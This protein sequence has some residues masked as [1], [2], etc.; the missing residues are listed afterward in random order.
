MPSFD[1]VSEVDKHEAQNAVDQA[2]REL[3][4]R[5]DFKGVNASFELKDFAVTL[6]ANEE[7]QIEQMKPMLE[8]SLIKRK[9]KV[10][11]LEY[12]DLAGAGKQ[13]KMIATLRQGIDKDLARKMVKIVKDSK[14]KVQASI[15]GEMVRVQGKARDDLQAVMALFRNDDSIEMPLAFKNFK[16]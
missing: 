6:T 10:S 4:T 12:G 1:V 3:S 7:F 11:C 16:D 13:V 5:F 14:L 8:S 9:I 2:N 15:Q